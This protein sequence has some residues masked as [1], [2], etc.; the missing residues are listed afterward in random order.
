MR[1]KVIIAV[2][3]MIF[4]LMSIT[5]AGI[6]NYY[7]KIEGMAE[8]R[9]PIFYAGGH[10]EGVYY[11]L[12]INTPPIKEEVISLSNG[13][14]IVFKT[15]PLGVNGFYKARFDIHIWAK[16]SNPNSI[17]QFKVFRIDSNQIEHEICTPAPI[18][19]GATERFTH[20]HTNCTSEG[21]ISMSPDDSFGLEIH[22]VGGST[23]YWIMTGHEYAEGYT[24]IEVS[25]A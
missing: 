6:L 25:K 4:L 19:V 21:E 10:A 12:F 24:R 15:E 9:G 22:G 13:N 7:G 5:Y 8:V 23:E 20:Y 2:F 17:L 14:R 11:N 1:G 3:G 18:S 16:T